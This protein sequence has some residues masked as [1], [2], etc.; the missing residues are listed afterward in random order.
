MSKPAKPQSPIVTAAQITAAQ[1][2]KIHPMNAKSIRHS[3]CISDM[4]KPLCA[5]QS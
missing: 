3:A 1:K 2:D 4:G 5:V